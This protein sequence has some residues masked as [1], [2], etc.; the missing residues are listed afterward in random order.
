MLEERSQS[1]GFHLKGRL[2]SRETFSASFADSDIFGSRDEDD[3]VSAGCPGSFSRGSSSRY[4]FSSELTSEMEEA[5]EQLGQWLEASKAEDKE[6]CEG[7]SEDLQ[8]RGNEAGLKRTMSDSL[9]AL[10]GTRDSG[11][12]SFHRSFERLSAKKSG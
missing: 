6:V 7:M 2:G 3:D 11:G 5:F 1:P 8:R 9:A 12:E 4:S 10:P